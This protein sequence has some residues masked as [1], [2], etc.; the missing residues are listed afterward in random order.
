VSSKEGTFSKERGHDSQEKNSVIFGRNIFLLWEA[1]LYGSVQ[2]IRF[3]TVSTVVWI[4]HGN[5]GIS[6]T[7]FEADFRIFVVVFGPYRTVRTAGLW[8]RKTRY[9]RGHTAVRFWHKNEADFCGTDL[10][11]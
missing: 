11:L 2:S 3:C 7:V 9:G 8:A 4:W 10:V 1:V 6:G 5:R